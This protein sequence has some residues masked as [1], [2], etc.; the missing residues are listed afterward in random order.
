MNRKFACY[1]KKLHLK[2][3]RNMILKTV[4]TYYSIIAEKKTFRKLRELL[5]QSD[6]EKIFKDEALHH[7]QIVLMK[8]LMIT[9]I[10]AVIGLSGL[11]NQ[12]KLDIN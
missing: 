10:K 4:S 1:G 8:L 7:L 5:I 12:E 2:A 6:Y 11:V 9:F 3:I